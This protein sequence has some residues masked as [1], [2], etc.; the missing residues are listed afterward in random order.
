MNIPPVLHTLANEEKNTRRNKEDTS[1]SSM[2]SKYELFELRK[3]A[4]LNHVVEQEEDIESVEITDT[5]KMGQRSKGITASGETQ[6]PSTS[7]TQL[8]ER[9]ESL[10]VSSFVRPANR[11]KDINDR[12]KEINMRNEKLK[13][14][15][16]AQY[17]KH[18]PPNQSRLMST[19]DI[20]E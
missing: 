14:E 1:N 20:K 7:N 15:T 5:G 12:F 17:S 3:R 8:I 19:F 11:E 2:D 13:A 18:T 10:E 6:Q 9:Q 4:K 16:Y